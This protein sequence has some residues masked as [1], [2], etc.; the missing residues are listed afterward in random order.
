M[1]PKEAT[2]TIDLVTKLNN[3]I[4]CMPINPNL[5]F[6]TDDTTMHV[7]EGVEEK[8]ASGEL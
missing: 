3:N 7:F 6:S 4:P 2:E 5:I 1:L 8:R